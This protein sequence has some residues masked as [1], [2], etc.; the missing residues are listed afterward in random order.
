MRLLVDERYERGEA[1]EGDDI[2]RVVNIADG[3]ILG[4]GID[5]DRFF[6][7]ELRLDLGGVEGAR[8][9]E[10][11]VSDSGS[12]VNRGSEKSSATPVASSLLAERGILRGK[13]KI[14]GGNLGEDDELLLSMSDSFLAVR[15]LSSAFAL[16][17]RRGL[18]R[19][20][21]EPITLSPVVSSIGSQM[22]SA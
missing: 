19:V 22:L 9:G 13:V 14:G 1:V 10:D 4:E 15:G 18:V 3:E 16:P 12:V 8:R 11:S 6:R 20:P 7:L 17:L 21:A 5:G 2:C